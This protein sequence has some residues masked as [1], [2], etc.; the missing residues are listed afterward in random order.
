MSF[1]IRYSY[2]GIGR[3]EDGEQLDGCEVSAARAGD[4]RDSRYRPDILGVQEARDLQIVDLREALPEFEFYGVGRDDGKTGGEYTGI[5]Y[6]KDRFAR[7]DGG[8]FWLSATPEKPGTSFLLSA[9]R[10]SANGILGAPARQ[11]I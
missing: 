6:R 5:F 2:G 4:P 9:G 3:R 11:A 8:S 7:S 10:M 1:N